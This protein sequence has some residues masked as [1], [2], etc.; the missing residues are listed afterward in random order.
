MGAGG[1]GLVEVQVAHLGA[2][3]GGPVD[4]AGAAAACGGAALQF[5]GLALGGGHGLGGRAVGGRLVRRGGSAPGRG[6]LSGL[7]G[8]PGGLVAVNIALLHPGKAPGAAAV[9]GGGR[10]GAAAFGFVF[11]LVQHPAGGGAPGIDGARVPGVVDGSCSVAGVQPAW[12]AH[13]VPPFCSKIREQAR[14]EILISR[15]AVSGLRPGRPRLHRRRGCPPA[16]PRSRGP[17]APLFV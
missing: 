15:Q 14:S 3:S 6:G 12:L 5:H 11:F 1:P 9:A 4:G 10:L 7:R 16:P 13:N 8:A 2:G 17:A